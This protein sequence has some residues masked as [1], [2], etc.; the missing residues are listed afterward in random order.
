MAGDQK[1]LHAGDQ[2]TYSIAAKRK[3]L[4]LLPDKAI[5]RIRRVQH[6]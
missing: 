6:P 4:K 5:E 2:V 3:R 1:T